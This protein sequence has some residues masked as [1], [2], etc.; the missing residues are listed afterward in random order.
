[1][2]GSRDRIR[3]LAVLAL[4]AIPAWGHFLTLRQTDGPVAVELYLPP[5]GIAA[6]ATSELFFRVF[7]ANGDKPVA[8]SGVDSGVTMPFMPGMPPITPAIRS[9]GYPG[10]YALRA[11]FPHGGFY[12]VGITCTAAGQATP[13]KV[14]FLVEVL[15]ERSGSPD[16]V[17]PFSLKLEP[18]APTVAGKSARLVLSVWSRETGARVT[19]FDIVHEKILHL[20][21]VRADLGAFFHEHPTPKPDGTFALDFTFPSGGKWLLYADSAPRGAGSFI[22]H[23]SIAVR[24]PMTAAIVPP[25]EDMVLRMVQPDR[26]RPHREVSLVFNL[27]EASGPPV[28]DVEPWLGAPAHLMMIERESTEFVHSH[29]D[30]PTGQAM[31]RG[32]FVFNARFPRPGVYQCWAQ[33]QRHGRIHTFSFEVQVSEEG[34]S[35]AALR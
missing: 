4:C 23:V 17:Q 24:G 32:T 26:I 25:A 13:S 31:R 6:G 35:S 22:T 28:T 29:P 16:R 5:E 9:L 27:R 33:L 3:R 15:D 12:R 14:S 20:F 8:V 34:V 10:S 30:D 2:S 11:A 21:V 1:M 18:G 19:Q 7:L